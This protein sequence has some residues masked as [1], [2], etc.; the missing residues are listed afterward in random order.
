[1]L[2]V[3]MLLWNTGMFETT[4]EGIS[5]RPVAE[6]TAVQVADA[7]TRA[8]ALGTAIGLSRNLWAG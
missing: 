5:E 7:L 6:C 3:D 1:M 2:Y 4:L 8:F